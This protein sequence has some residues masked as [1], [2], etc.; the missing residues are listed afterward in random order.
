MVVNPDSAVLQLPDSMEEKLPVDGDHYT[1][2]KF[3]SNTSNTYTSVLEKLRQF[4]K[5]AP[6]VVSTRFGKQPDLH[7][8]QPFSRTGHK[9]DSFAKSQQQVHHLSQY[10]FKETLD[11]RSATK[12]LREFAIIMK[13]PEVTAVKYPSLVMNQK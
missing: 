3:D 5:G 4:E 8:T 1:I 13:Q 11:L 6:N 7:I 2:V 10:S 9:A 12:L